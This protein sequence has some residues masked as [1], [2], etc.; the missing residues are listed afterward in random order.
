MGIPPKDIGP[1]QT[2][3]IKQTQ[4]LIMSPQMQQA[5]HL[6]Q[7]PLMELSALIDLELQ[8]NPLLEQAQESTSREEKEI[9]EY[10]NEEKEVTFDDH[11]F[12]V[13]EQLDQEYQ[14]HFEQNENYHINRSPD[15]AKLKSFQEQSIREESS[16]YEHLMTQIQES[17]DKPED[18]LMAEVIIGYIDEKGYLQSPIQE[19]AFFHGYQGDE[20]EKILKIIQTFHPL[21][22]GARNLQECLLIQLRAQGKEKTLAYR[23]VAKYFDDMLH[24]RVPIIQKAVKH[25]PQEIHEAI[26]NDIS[27]LDLHPGTLYSQMVP[28][29]I[30]PDIMINEEEG[31]LIITLPDES[32]PAIRLNSRY[33]KML[34]NDSLEEETRTFIK[35]KV[36]AAKWLIH[37]I[38]QRNQTIRRIAQSI[39]QRQHNFFL[40]AEGDLV[41]MNMKMIA[42]ELELHESTI[43]RAVANK[44]IDTPRGILP[45]RSFFT[46]AY[47]TEEGH[48]ISSNTVRDAI[49]RL[50]DSEDKRKPL[51]DEKLSSILKRQGI[52]CARRTIAKYRTELSIGNASQRKQF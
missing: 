16:L 33:L 46:N 51:S 35:R 38:D 25:T 1:K 39:A 20:A 8:R 5:I 15:E 18:K 41:P 10:N 19:I 42:D 43:A 29:H 44:Y 3:S 36:I 47:V 4:R 30:T 45:M 9:T 31:T 48:D 27:P 13:L 49:Q 28:Q 12:R 21:G 11:D 2:L 52:T 22:V 23:I 37:N 32:M 50:I 24:N 7:I 17:I 14:D 40:K 6:L 26:E 34:K